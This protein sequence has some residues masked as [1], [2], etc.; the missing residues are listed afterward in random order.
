[1]SPEAQHLRIMEFSR[2]NLEEPDQTISMKNSVYAE[3]FGDT[4]VCCTSTTLSGDV[5]RS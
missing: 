3:V 5:G 2:R 1:M 4:A